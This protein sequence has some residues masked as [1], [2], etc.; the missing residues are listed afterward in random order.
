MNK[1]AN[2]TL[3]GILG[4]FGAGIIVVSL[5]AKDIS[6]WWALLGT[7]FLYLAFLANK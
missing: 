3:S 7:L 5:A 4:L 6:N 2:W 1:K